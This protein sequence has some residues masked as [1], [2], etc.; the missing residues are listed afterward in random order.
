M[1]LLAL[2]LLLS[3]AA[4]AYESP[5]QPVVFSDEVDVWSA[6]EFDTGPLPSGSPVTVRFYIA[7]DGGAYT[8]IESA[9]LMEWPDPLSQ[10]W[11]SYPSGGT[12]ALITD[13]SLNLDL[14]WDIFGV[15]GTEPLWSEGLFFEDAMTFD[16]LLLP[17]GNPESASVQAAGGSLQS[18]NFSQSVVTGVEV[19]FSMDLIPQAQADL[20]GVRI[21]NTDGSALIATDF[22]G[23]VSIFDVPASHPGWIELLSTYQA[24]LAATLSLVLTPAVD[25]CVIGQCFE[26]AAFD[27]PIDLIDTEQA[28]SF[29][30]VL[31]NHPLPSI[32]PP[33]PSHDFGE[34]LVG[35]TLNF[36]LPLSNQGEMY[37]EGWVE[38]VGAE[39][40]TVFPE[41]FFAQPGETD[42]VV[43]SFAPDE[44]IET[45]AILRI[46]SNDPRQPELEIPLRGLGFVPEP[47][48]SDDGYSYEG[49]SLGVSG[50]GC[51]TSSPWSVSWLGLLPLVM[52]RRRRG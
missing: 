23:D 49:R 46:T 11:A 43:V 1:R 6:V 15:S 51:S 21:D 19:A 50:C 47:E 22:E 41:Y 10:S 13:I 38:V 20:A 28:R 45:T 18:F 2:G 7:S 14:S 40:I 9:S 30:P 34:V 24:Q 37:L 44:A 29:A 35:N 27:I 8:D 25:L 17:Q 33:D 42:G 39:N 32:I 26:L 3:P 12:L 31:V 4:M 5:E 52:V 16:G 36:E 48:T